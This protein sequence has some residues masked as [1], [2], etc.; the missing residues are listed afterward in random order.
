MAAS[1][2]PIVDELRK[3]TTCDVSDAL[4]K[5]GHEKGGFLPGITMWSPERQKGDT[6]IVG[7]AYT[8]K[9]VHANSPEAKIDSHYIDGLPEDCVVFISCP[10]DVTNAVFGGLMATRARAS[11]A[12]GTIID[13][14][15]RDLQEQRDLKYPVFARDV[16]TAAPYGAV[17]V[18]AV[19]IPVELQDTE[20]KV[21]ISP[22]DYL[23]GDLNGVVVLPRE[24]AEQAI[25]LMEKQIAVD[26]QMAVALKGNMSFTEASQNFRI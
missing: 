3:Y 12:A 23:M 9:Y 24:M 18:T 8:V 16:G 2:D 22:G 7:L 25:P 6:K 21:V 13:G 19:N 26:A 11:G 15:F 17:K 20:T 5:L 10:Q 14:R 4:C 1:K